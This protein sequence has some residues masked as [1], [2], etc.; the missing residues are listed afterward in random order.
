MS[1]Q[2]T[3][4]IQIHQGGP[5]NVTVT[6]NPPRCVPSDVLIRLNHVEAQ[7]LMNILYPPKEWQTV[8]EDNFEVDL[9]DYIGTEAGIEARQ[10][11]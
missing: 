3:Q 5:S 11:K 10:A 8:A 9:Y 7:L 4:L 1:A 6:I 2:T